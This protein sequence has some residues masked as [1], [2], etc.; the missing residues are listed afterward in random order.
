MSKVSLFKE[1][2]INGKKA[3]FLFVESYKKEERIEKVRN[4]LSDNSWIASVSPYLKASYED[5]LTITLNAFDTEIEKAPT[6]EILSYIGERIVT[7]CS[8][9]AIED[10]LHFRK[11]PLGEIFK[12]RADGNGGF[13]YYNEN[14]TDFYIVFG[15]GKFVDEINA[16]GRAL[17]QV[18]DFIDAK[19]DSTDLPDLQGLVDPESIKNFSDGK[20]TFSAGFSFFSKKEKISAIIENIKKNSDFIELIGQYDLIVVGVI[21]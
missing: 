21:F 6:D 15:E 3:T 20:K 11:L 4:A 17:S 1:E 7:L 12:S 2:T 13:D 16:Y 10:Q 19:K 9:D 8:C 5:R 18:K 14:I